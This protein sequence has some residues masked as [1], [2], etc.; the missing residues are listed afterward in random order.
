[1]SLE[2][3]NFYDFYFLKVLI[4][5]QS[6]YNKLKESKHSQILIQRKYTVSSPFTIFSSIHFSFYFTQ[7]RKCTLTLAQWFALCIR[8]VVSTA[9]KY[10]CYKVITNRGLNSVLWF[11]TLHRKYIEFPFGFGTW[12]PVIEHHRSMVMEGT[13]Q[14]KYRFCCCGLLRTSYTQ[15]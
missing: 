1:M 6:I 3:Y 7:M 13:K 2:M 9:V 10:F 4:L 8:R 15:R 12:V 14:N 11:L 5:S